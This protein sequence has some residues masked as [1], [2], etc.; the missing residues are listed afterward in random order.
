MQ[1]VFVQSSAPKRLQKQPIF[2][3]DSTTKCPAVS[4]S[5]RGRNASLAGPRGRALPIN[6]VLVSATRY[7][8]A[9]AGVHYAYRN[10]QQTTPNVPGALT[11]AVHAQ[12]RTCPRFGQSSLLSE[13]SLVGSRKGCNRRFSAYGAKRIE[14]TSAAKVNVET[15][16][17]SRPGPVLSSS[18]RR[19]Q[20]R[21]SRF[22]CVLTLG[23]GT[24][25]RTLPLAAGSA[26][27]SSSWL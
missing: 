4:P 21:S 13:G 23:E 12:R 17:R 7:A 3:H 9:P 22:T 8:Y 26:D 20:S 18:S 25:S 14:P 10:E 27:S 16:P 15:G 11:G 2:V 19:S 1:P 6:N 24:K 5:K